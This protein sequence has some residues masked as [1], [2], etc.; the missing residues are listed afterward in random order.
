MIGR[1]TGAL[2]SIAAV[3]PGV[4]VLV[5]TR[6]GVLCSAWLASGRQLAEWQATY[7]GD[8]H[9]VEVEGDQIRWTG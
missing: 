2:H 1:A 6:A 9:G 8:V 7:N 3:H 5:V 4:R